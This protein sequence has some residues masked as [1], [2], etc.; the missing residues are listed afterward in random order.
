[1]LDYAVLKKKKKNF[2]KNIEIFDIREAI[3]QVIEILKDKAEM[4]KLCINTQF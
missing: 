4:R 2:R 3:D 1:M